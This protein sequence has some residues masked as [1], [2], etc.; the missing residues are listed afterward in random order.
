MKPVI[1]DSEQKDN[2]L[3]DEL[4]KG[5][6][7]SR[8]N[9]SELSITPSERRAAVGAKA[10][11]SFTLWMRGLTINRSLGGRHLFD[12]TLV[13]IERQGDLVSK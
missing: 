3:L 2:K 11:K 1:N 10:D 5:S 13:T 8:R 7:E 12:L 4:L 6:C 9:N